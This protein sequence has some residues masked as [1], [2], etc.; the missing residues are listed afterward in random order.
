MTGRERAAHIARLLIE[1]CLKNVC[2]QD[3]IAEP[4]ISFFTE[5]SFRNSPAVRIDYD[6]AYCIAS[7]GEGLAATRSKAWGD[8][9]RI[10]P[11]EE[12]DYVDPLFVT[13]IFKPTSRYNRRFEQR[14]RLKE[15]LGQRFRPLVETAKRHT[16]TIFLRDLTD[17]QAEAIRRRVDV[18][19]GIFW[20]SAKGKI[21]LDL[22]PRMIQL[23]LFER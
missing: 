5:E 1:A 11:L 21:F 17:E 13:Y 7:I 15:L 4:D 9:P 3:L 18:E 14:K 16:K 22:P 12:F 20:R 2:I 8:G 10:L 19:P 23:E 6:E